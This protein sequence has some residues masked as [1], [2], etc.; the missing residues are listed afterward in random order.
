M[1]SHFVL[2]F[3]L[4]YTWKTAVIN[5]ANNRIDVIN[6]EVKIAEQI[7]L[8]YLNT[9][10]RAIYRTYDLWFNQHHCSL[11][12]I[13]SQE[14]WQLSSAIVIMTSSHSQQEHKL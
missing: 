10:K 11:S 7:L 5:E 13:S 9:S 3:Q 12:E 6:H 1:I 14:W 2:L 8:L 4:L